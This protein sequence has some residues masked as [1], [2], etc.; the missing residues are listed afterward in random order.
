M[1]VVENHWKILVVLGAIVIS[2]GSFAMF[3][4]PIIQGITSTVTPTVTSGPTPTPYTGDPKEA[5]MKADTFGITITL[6][7]TNPPFHKAPATCEGGLAIDIL[8][9]TSSSMKKP[10]DN[11]K[12]DALKEAVNNIISQIP[13]EA[14]LAVQRFDK[15]SRSIFGPMILHDGKSEI[16]DAIKEIVPS[17]EGG[18][19][20]QEGLYKAK[21]IIDEANTMFPGR[22]WT[23]ILISD[24]SPYPYPSQDGTEVASQLKDEGIKIVTIG[25]DLDQEVNVS[26]EKAK[27]LMRDMASSPSEFYDANSD[28]IGNIYRVLTGKLCQ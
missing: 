14:V 15:Q 21:K 23:L 18:T 24:G 25:L 28:D 7:P 20:T 17:S 4:Q 19:H 3:D 10:Q 22:S 27:E 13:E 5:R 11:P 1:G 2:L 8:L 9:D 16:K 26:P 6:K 12:I